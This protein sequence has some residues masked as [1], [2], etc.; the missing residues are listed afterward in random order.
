MEKGKILNKADSILNSENKGTADRRNS[1][2][3]EY[4]RF[5][6]VTD[7]KPTFLDKDA[8]MIEINHW[9]DQFN[10]YITMGYEGNP[11]DKGISMHVSPS[12]T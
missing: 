5:S 8:T 2:V 11:P 4:G 6:A 12:Y 7:L 10:N 9:A 3:T 1:M